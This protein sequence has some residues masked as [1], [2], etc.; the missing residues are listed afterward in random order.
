[1]RNGW[2]PTRKIIYLK[3]QVKRLSG[4]ALYAMKILFVRIRVR[5]CASLTA[6]A[7]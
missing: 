4:I 5:A 3:Y 7:L 2:N 6:K 1:M